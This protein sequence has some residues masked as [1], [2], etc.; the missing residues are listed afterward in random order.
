[1]EYLYS[2]NLLCRKS[3]VLRDL[4]EN[5]KWDLRY[6]EFGFFV[7]V[8]SQTATEYSLSLVLFS[9]RL[10]VYCDI[11]LCKSGVRVETE[12]Y[13]TPISVNSWI[14][15]EEELDKFMRLRKVDLDQRCIEMV[16][17]VKVIGTLDCFSSKGIIIR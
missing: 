11:L 14:E 12:L 9:D 13:P 15:L 6:K 4:C 1:M 7:S 8:Y 2:M 17:N 16:D 3:Q 5:N 10:N